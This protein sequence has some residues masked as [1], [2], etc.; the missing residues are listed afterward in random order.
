MSDFKNS[1]PALDPMG[2]GGAPLGDMFA[3]SDDARARET[4]ETAWAH[5]IRYYDTSPHYGA[6]LSEQRFGSFLA[7]K[8]RSAYVLSTKVGRVL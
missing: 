4:L 5:G 7:R 8:P 6:G 2:F 1:G 3:R